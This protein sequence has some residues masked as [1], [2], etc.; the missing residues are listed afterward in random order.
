LKRTIS[1][2]FK[3]LVVS[4]L[5]IAICAICLLYVNSYLLNISLPI[6]LYFHV[7][8]ATLFV[9]QLSRWLYHNSF[10]KEPVKDII[11]QFV[12]GNKNFIYTSLTISAVVAFI[13]FFILPNITK[14]WI[15]FVG[16]ISV[17]Y[18]LKLKTS[19]GY[20]RLR[21]IPF[22]KIILI[23]L[24]WSISTII[25]PASIYS[26]TP[27]AF[28]LFIIQNI[29]ILFITIP[30]DIN[31]FKT[32]FHNK[33]KTIPVYFG[34]KVSKILHVILGVIYL[35]AMLFWIYNYSNGSYLFD[36]IFLLLLLIK[37]IFLS[38]LTIKKSE[39]IEKWKIMMFYDGSM[40]LYAIIIFISSK[41]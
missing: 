34:I 7:F 33:V 36:L 11:Y 29:F 26:I 28:Y 14:I 39:N 18:P 5:Y 31:D 38:I 22:I 12:E 35:L 20:F 8:A 27:K 1:T 10:P 15:G 6:A 21:D 32:D 24:V 41:F 17:L 25:L 16:L 3:K 13:S 37:I 23:S 2:L 19:K 30:F 9:Y 4:N 40:I